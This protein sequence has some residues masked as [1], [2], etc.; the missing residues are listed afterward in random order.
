MV[1]DVIMSVSFSNVKKA[2]IILLFHS[3]AKKNPFIPSSKKD[4]I[5]KS[6]DGTARHTAPLIAIQLAPSTGGSF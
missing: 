1:Y 2:G 3:L 4:G 6:I 5:H